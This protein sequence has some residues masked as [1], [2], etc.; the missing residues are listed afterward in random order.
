VGCFG[1]CVGAGKRERTGG[2]GLDGWAR[3]V[4]RFRENGGG[5][6]SGLSGGAASGLS[7]GAAGDAVMAAA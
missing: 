5:A 2:S 3:Q 4:V 6:A 1:W 7:G